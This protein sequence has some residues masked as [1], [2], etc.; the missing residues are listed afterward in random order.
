MWKELGRFGMGPP[1]GGG[2]QQPG[3]G[4]RT[5]LRRNN[6]LLWI[7]V[8]GAIL[9][10]TQTDGSLFGNIDQTHVSRMTLTP[11]EITGEFALIDHTGMPRT[12]QDFLGKHTLVYFG[13]T[14]CPDVCPSAML[15]MS[16]VIEDLEAQATSVQPLF[17]TVDPQRDTV[18]KL[19]AYVSALAPGL[20]GLTGSEAAIGQALESFGIYRRSHATGLDDPDYLVDHAAFFYLMGPA[21]KFI[22]YFEAARG[23]DQAR[24][25]HRAGA[26]G[27]S[28]RGV[29]HHPRRAGVR[30]RQDRAVRGP[31]RALPQGR[32]RRPGLQVGARLHRPRLSPHG[33]RA[34]TASIS[35]P[36]A[37][38]PSTLARR[39]AALWVG[40]R[41]RD[42]RGRHGP[43]RRRPRRHRVHR[44][45]RGPAGA[46]PWCWW[47]TCA[48][49][50][51][52]GGRACRGLR[53]PPPGRGGRGR[54]PQPGGGRGA[55][56]AA[57]RRPRRALHHG[58]R[59]RAEDG[60]TESSLAASR[61][62][63]GLR[64][65]RCRGWR[66]SRQRSLPDRSMPRRWP[67]WRARLQ[68]GLPRR[69]VRRSPRLAS[70]SRWHGMR[71]SAS[72]TTR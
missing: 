8:I 46:C 3:G 51:R 14:W 36:G 60:Y 35:T 66:T 63:A 41:P 56:A 16:Q 72:A 62:R 21:G 40:R 17:I 12:N 37:C 20:V 10:Y 23:A 59:R 24:P 38:G 31:A 65:R 54:H 15:T 4:Q 61:P 70:G 13:F 39:V 19:A 67:P 33:E 26:L 32:P 1:S 68:M 29:R 25:G 28:R 44:R 18:E 2:G 57:P 49:P 50:G 64:E 7:L 69:R 5:P 58:L 43:L 30:Q 52:L 22:Q 48:G 42:R 53:Q 55:R 34:A 9:I 45:P 11:E 6:P 71:P 27:L 47:W